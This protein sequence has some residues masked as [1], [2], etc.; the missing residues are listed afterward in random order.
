MGRNGRECKGVG[1]NGKEWEGVVFILKSA[2]EWE[3]V[4]MSGKELRPWI[5]PRKEQGPRE[6]NNINEKPIEKQPW[7]NRKTQHSQAR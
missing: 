2:N 5:Y 4:E 3:R 7:I 1:G 6:G